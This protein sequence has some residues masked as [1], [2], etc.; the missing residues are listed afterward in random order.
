MMIFSFLGVILLSYI[1]GALSVAT[2]YSQDK[3][4]GLLVVSSVICY[5]ILLTYLNYNKKP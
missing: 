5:I 2:P 4:V 1:L 3:I